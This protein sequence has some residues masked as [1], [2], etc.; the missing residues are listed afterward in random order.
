VTSRWLLVAK[1]PR[2]W[3][4]AAA[5]VLSGENSQPQFISDAFVTPETPYG[6]L[7]LGKPSQCPGTFPY[8]S[9]AKLQ[10]FDQK[11]SLFTAQANYATD[12]GFAMWVPPHQGFINGNSYLQ[13]FTLG[14]GPANNPGE[15]GAAGNKTAEWSYKQTLLPLLHGQAPGR[16]VIMA[17]PCLADN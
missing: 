14:A 9:K 1:Q 3:R 4:S 11:D 12:I 8:P 16:V 6:K 15:T 10:P 2:G 13:L 7:P 17:I 5:R